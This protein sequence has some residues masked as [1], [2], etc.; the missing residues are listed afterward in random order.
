MGT[1]FP[2]EKKRDQSH[3]ISTPYCTPLW[4]SFLRPWICRIC[5]VWMPDSAL[6]A[7][8]SGGYGESVAV[9]AIRMPMLCVSN[10]KGGTPELVETRYA[11]LVLVLPTTNHSVCVPPSTSWSHWE[12]LL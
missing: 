11:K 12:F 8:S 1:H 2:F 5:A 9:A 4:L 10:F 3:L 6:G 7:A